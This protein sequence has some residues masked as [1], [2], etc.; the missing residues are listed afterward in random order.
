MAKISAQSVKAYKNHKF[1]N[2]PDARLIRMMAEYLEPLSRFRYHEIADTIVFFGSSRIRS[3]DSVHKD[4]EKFKKL[5]S[6]ARQK[7]HR[8]LAKLKVEL[9]MAHYYDDALVLSRKLTEWSKSLEKGQRRFTVCTGGSGGI[10]EAANRGA[11]EANGLSIGLNISLPLE[12][13]ANP[14]ITPDLGFEFHYFFMRKFWFVYLAKALII[15]PGGFG[16]LDELFE[17]LTLMQTKKTRKKMPVVVYGTDYWNEVINFDALVRRG[18]IEAKDLNLIHFSN[19]PQET[20]SY[21]SR[22]LSKLH[23][24]RKKGG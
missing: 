11:R 5:S 9:D 19:D 7:N 22:T 21:L 13:A 1:L 15:F 16:T 10:M 4:I 3:S 8:T 14:Y 2:S 24:K 20:F 12:E 18:S 6:R 23:L 17:V